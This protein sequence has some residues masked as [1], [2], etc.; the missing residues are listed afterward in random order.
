MSNFEPEF[1][2]DNGRTKGAFQSALL[3]VPH[4]P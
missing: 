2:G 1:Y 3:A 4:R